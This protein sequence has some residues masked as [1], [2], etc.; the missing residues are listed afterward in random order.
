L[1][2]SDL[3]IGLFDSGAGGLSVA[4][5]FSSLLP[6]EDLLYFADT[7]R[8][9][10]GDRP[11][12]EVKGFALEICDFLAESGVKAI[13]MAC[14]IS[15]AVALGE[16][17]RRF[18]QIPIIGVIEPGVSAALAQG[19]RNIGVLATKGT[20]ESGAYPKA[21]A[22]LDASIRVTQSAAPRFVPIVE[23][24]KV[25]TENALDASLEYLAPLAQA[26]CDTIIYGCTHYPFLERAIK[27][28][29]REL[30]AGYAL[31]CFVDPAIET[32]KTAALELE[33]RGLLASAENISANRYF[34][35]DHPSILARQ[36]RLFLDGAMIAPVRH[37]WPSPVHA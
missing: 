22:A 37:A 30:F 14:N 20:V 28:A 11:L 6:S 33:R 9:P 34:T 24:G 4:R 1:P 13:V 35:S 21:A 15:S 23:A 29:A 32:A 8:A 19:G 27:K 17:R 5:A 3:P 25:D 7:Q 36:A 18:P 12:D 16:A 2:F 10:Y 31:P 26:H